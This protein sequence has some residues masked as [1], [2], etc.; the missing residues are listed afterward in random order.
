LASFQN[1]FWGQIGKGEKIVE[2]SK[3]LLLIFPFA[4]WY[5]DSRSAQNGTR[6]LA[7]LNVRGPDG[8]D[9]MIGRTAWK[10]LKLE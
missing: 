8:L 4:G 6:W 7:G 3:N 2:K 5:T 1:A 9:V 10:K